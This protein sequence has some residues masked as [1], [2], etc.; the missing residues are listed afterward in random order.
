[1]FSFQRYFNRKIWNSSW[2]KSSGMKLGVNE[3]KWRVYFQWHF[4]RKIWNSFETKA[5]YEAW[6]SHS[7]LFDVLVMLDFPTLNCS[8]GNGTLWKSGSGYSVHSSR[9]WLV[10]KTP[11]LH[12]Q[13]NS[14]LFNWYDNNWPRNFHHLFIC[15]KVSIIVRSE[16]GIN[17]ASF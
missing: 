4:N 12:L 8:Y 15:T 1:M 16:F 14:A 17:K 13:D 3:I 6:S 7:I 5:W 11:P 9:D 2:N 10:L